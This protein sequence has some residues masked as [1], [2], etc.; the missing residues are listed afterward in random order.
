MK[1]NTFLPTNPF[2]NYGG[3]EKI[4]LDIYDFLGTKEIELIFSYPDKDSI[5]FT[6][7]QAIAK[8]LSE[9]TN[10]TFI[11]GHLSLHALT[12]VMFCRNKTKIL[13][14]PFWHDPVQHSANSKI[15][16]N[17]RKLWDK[18]FLKFIIKNSFRIFVLSDY[19]RS[20]LIDISCESS[21][22]FIT[23][24]IPVSKPAYNMIQDV[25]ISR[26][27]DCLFV[28]RDAHNK[29]LKL[30]LD[31]TKKMPLYKFCIVSKLEYNSDFSTKENSNITILDSIDEIELL[32]LYKRSK[33]LIIPSAYESYCLVAAEGIAQGCIVLGSPF[34]YGKS[35]FKKFKNYME[36]TSFPYSLAEDALR[37]LDDY[38]FQNQFDLALDIFSAEKSYAPLLR[39]LDK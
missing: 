1:I 20:S 36:F 31:M 13:Y 34:V 26:D 32:H 11:A 2:K 39:I 22:K 17:I 35:V 23:Y 38:S 28:G 37:V 8:R 14:F 15:K 10:F 6:K 27:I 12:A 29:N 25:S 9:D 4:F 16:Q 18:I 30:V 33:V 5:F 21:K 7:T 19:E 3:I 24:H